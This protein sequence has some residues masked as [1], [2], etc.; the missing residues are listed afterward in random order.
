MT[1]HLTDETIDLLADAGDDPFDLD[2]ELLGHLDSCPACRRELAL[3][4]TVD[5]GLAAVPRMVAPPALLEGVMAALA[6]ARS[7]RRRAFAWLSAVS[8]AAA[9]VV[10]CWLAAGGAA[11][12]ALEAVEFTRSV[13]FAARVATAVGESLPLE[14]LIACAL[15]LVVSSA[16][17]GRVMG[18]VSQE[19]TP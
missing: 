8:I 1:P 14:L 15:V 12:V 17:L 7:A 10:A 6:A 11:V 2:E 9:A 3:A 5:E 19:M 16:V 13:R 18:R 4:R